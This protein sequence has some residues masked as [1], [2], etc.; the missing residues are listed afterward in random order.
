MDSNQIIYTIN[1]KT[2][3]NTENIMV[4]EWDNVKVKLVNKSKS[5]DHPMHLHGQFFQV[6][7]KNGKPLTES[8]V[9]KDTINLEPGEEYEIAHLKQITL[10]TGSSTATTCTMLQLGWL[11]K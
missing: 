8:P 1:G 6:L 7:S 11:H 4:K 2:F 10:E 3:L 5:D 9:I